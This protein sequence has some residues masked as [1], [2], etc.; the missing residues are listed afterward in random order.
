MAEKKI[1]F[2]QEDIMQLLDKL[3]DNS[4][5]GLSKV[6]PPISV[7]AEDYLAKHESVDSAAKSFIKYQI[8]KC[9]TSGF[10][11]GLGGLIT[12][13][14]AI[15]AN[16]SSVLYV[17]M[18]MIACL[19]YMG[20]YDTASDQ[21][22]TLVYACLAGIS[23]DQ[24]V[25]Q[26]GI[27]VGTKVANSMVK[28]IPGQVLTKINQ[29]VGFRLFTKFGT[30]GVINIGKAIPLVG[31]VISGGFDFAETSVIADRAY[32]MFILNDF[33]VSTKK[34]NVSNEEVFVVDAADFDLVDE[35]IDNNPQQ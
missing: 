23:L 32:K 1:Q 10:V 9:T 27:K 5:Q 6:S 7:L 11:T 20:G 13:P 3:Y 4:V 12:L 2:T 14:V 18:R 24:V 25:K 29:K 19:A 22:Q 35:V 16:I 17:Q 34:A 28:K 30:K 21:V 33:S 26:V 8:A 31:G 15:P